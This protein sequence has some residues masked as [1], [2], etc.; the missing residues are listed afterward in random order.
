MQLS[1][2]QHDIKFFI[3]SQMK[4]LLSAAKRSLIST[5]PQINLKD[6]LSTSVSLE[7]NYTISCQ[8]VK[9]CSTDFKIKFKILLQLNCET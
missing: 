8:N 4:Y 1:L 5:L 3:D 6:Q 9:S 2:L 7:M